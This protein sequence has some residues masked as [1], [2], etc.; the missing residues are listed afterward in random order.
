MQ[1]LYDSEN[2]VMK[3]LWEKGNMTAREISIIAAERLGWNKNT[4]YTILNKLIAKGYIKRTDP[5]FFCEALLTRQ[6]AE[7]QATRSLV[8]KIFDGS[9]TALFS[10]LL[11]DENLSSEELA[12]LRKM[13]EEYKF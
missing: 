13:V 5:N 12:E 2:K 7:K 8:D 9:R 11:R 4:T 1:T 10:A 3:I 6:E